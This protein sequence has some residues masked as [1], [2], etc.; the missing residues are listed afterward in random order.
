MINKKF[1]SVYFKETS[2]TKILLI[3][4]IQNKECRNQLQNIVEEI[5]FRE[6][7]F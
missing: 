5:A 6:E 3:I 4:L 2:I 1:E 7:D